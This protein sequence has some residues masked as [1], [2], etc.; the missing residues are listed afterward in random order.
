MQLLIRN[1]YALQASRLKSG[2]KQLA[3]LGH[4]TQNLYSKNAVYLDFTDARNVGNSHAYFIWGSYPK[5]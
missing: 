1:D 2:E 3:R 4:Y 5:K